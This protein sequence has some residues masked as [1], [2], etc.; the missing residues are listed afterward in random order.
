MS[1]NINEFPVIPT[2]TKIESKQVIS[3]EFKPEYFPSTL[4]TFICDEANR[5]T[6][7]PDGI[8]A[9]LVVA[10][11]TIAGGKFR[12][13]PKLFDNWLVVPNLYGAI[14]GN[15]STKKSALMSIALRALKEIEKNEKAK[16]KKALAQYKVDSELLGMKHSADKRKAKKLLDDGATLEDAKAALKFDDEM[17]VEPIER[18]L[19]CNDTTV[20]ALGIELAGNPYGVL[21]ESDEL[22]GFIKNM[23][24]PG[25]EGDRA[26]YL[27]A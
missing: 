18:V 9:G 16:H 1:A 10:L 27:T 5:M 12:M 2:F 14:L 6:T 26:F 8:A 19:I 17:P 13:K 7:T 24:K 21:M 22:T 23:D 3:P 20:E 15:P 4:A 25:C 11:G